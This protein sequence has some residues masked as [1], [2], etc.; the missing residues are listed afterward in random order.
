MDSNFDEKTRELVT[1]KGIKADKLLPILK[2]TNAY[3][4]EK[5]NQLVNF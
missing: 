2:R 1:K 4:Y 3:G 5:F